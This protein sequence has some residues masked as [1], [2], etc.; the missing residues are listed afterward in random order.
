MKTILLLIIASI[1]ASTIALE[2]NLAAEDNWPPYSGQN[3][4]GVSQVIIKKAFQKSGVKVKIDSYPYARAEKKVLNG[5]LDG[6]FN[7]SKQPSTLGKFH[8][9]KEPILKAKASFF[10][11]KKRSFKFRSLK[12]LPKGTAFILIRGFEYGKDFEQHKHKF[13]IEY[14]HSQEQIINMLISNRPAITIMYDEVAKY[15]LDRMPGT[16]KNIK[17]KPSHTSSIYLAFNKDSP[18]SKALSKKL[19]EGLRKLKR[20]DMYEELLNF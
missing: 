12:D 18:K 4:I 5:Q 14:V 7:V 19:D 15:H 3:E 1:S 10:Y 16:K 20:T 13:D 11:H 9:G 6:F 2:A 17:N 8:F